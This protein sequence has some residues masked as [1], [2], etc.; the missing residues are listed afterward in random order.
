M[1]LPRLK[2]IC[3]VVIIQKTNIKESSLKFPFDIPI[4]Y[5]TRD[6]IVKCLQ[7]EEESRVSW[8]D[9]YNHPLIKNDDGGE[10]THHYKMDR[11]LM[12][13]LKEL[14]LR[15]YTDAKSV[16]EVFMEYSYEKEMNLVEFYQA[17]QRFYPISFR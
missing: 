8:E 13:I 3:T 1:G 15:Y 17:Y 12:N 14:Q 7:L 11:N 6:F 4:G 9:V 2:L 16:E 5:H 10:L